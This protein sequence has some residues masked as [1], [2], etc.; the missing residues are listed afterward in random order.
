MSMSL[1]AGKPPARLGRPIQI[2]FSRGDDPE[3]PDGALWR[4]G[5]RVVLEDEDGALCDR[6]E[7]VVNG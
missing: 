7:D 5:A 6:C 4:I 2:V 3:H 1:N